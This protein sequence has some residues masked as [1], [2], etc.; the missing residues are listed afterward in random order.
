MKSSRSVNFYTDIR[1]YLESMIIVKLM[2]YE[3]KSTHQ[4]GIHFQN[5]SFP[6][7]HTSVTVVLKD[8][9]QELVKI[10]VS[11]THC[12]KGNGKVVPVL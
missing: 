4:V 10:R 6:K 7:L 5:E 3:Y 11:I 9:P 12:K 8:I 1:H 2:E